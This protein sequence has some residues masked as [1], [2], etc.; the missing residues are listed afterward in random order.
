MRFAGV[1]QSRDN[2]VVT[3]CRRFPEPFVRMMQRAMMNL[4][5]YGRLLDLSERRF[6]AARV[7]RKTAKQI[8]S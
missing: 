8:D 3:H 1:M 5:Y 4:N 6:Q 2:P 7:R